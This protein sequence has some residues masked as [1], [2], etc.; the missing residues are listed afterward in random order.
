ME[1]LELFERLGVALAAGLLVGLERGWRGRAGADGERAAGLRT[2]GLAGLLG[3]I[4][5]ALSAVSHPL[6]LAAGLLAF[7]LA[8]GAYTLLQARAERNFS[9]TGLVAAILTFTLGA[10]SVLGEPVVAIAAAVAMTILLALRDQLHGVIRNVTW[11]E[12]RAV[13]TLLAMTFLLLPVLPSRTID[14]WDAINPA[15]IWLL[16]ILIAAVSFVG[17][18]LV[19]TTGDRVGIGLASVTGGLTSSTATTIALS[20]M[21]AASG[22]SAMLLAGGVLMAG[23]TMMFRVIVIVFFI[24][25]TLATRLAPAVAIAG[26]I[27]AVAGML[28]I[29]RGKHAR[30]AAERPDFGLKNPFELGTA[31]KLAALIALIGLVA[32]VVTI[33]IGDR[34]VFAVAALSGL[35]DV[36]AVT[37]SFA[38]MAGDYVVVDAAALA[39]LVAVTANTLSKTVMAAWLGGRTFGM[40]VGVINA[41]A[42]AAMFVAWWWLPET[43]QL[44]GQ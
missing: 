24:G 42:I 23:A 12:L 11:L 13:L 38:R 25:P 5:G 41:T 31:L 39:V 28:M 27:C 44:V 40:L 37:L 10:Y 4:C 32:H 26:S 36:D 35:A 7:T 43:V 30:P 6:V 29:V 34:G 22:S 16:A 3:G 20:R 8:V 1:Q 9:A 17:Y 14:P 21:H 2:F 33:H 18:I 15:E 19:R